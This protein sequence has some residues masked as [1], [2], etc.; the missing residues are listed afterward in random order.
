MTPMP[1][2]SMLLA[3]AVTATGSTLVALL[4]LGLT[5]GWRIG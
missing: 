5:M 2:D 1:D 4:M 3:I